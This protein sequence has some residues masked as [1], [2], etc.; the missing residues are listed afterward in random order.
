MLWFRRFGALLM[1]SLGVSLLILPFPAR[2]NGEKTRELLR[3]EVREGPYDRDSAARR[4]GVDFIELSYEKMEGRP[5][6]REAV[7]SLMDRSGS[8]C[9]SAEEWKDLLAEFSRTDPQGLV[10][11]FRDGIYRIVEFEETGDEHGRDFICCD[12]EYL[13]VYNNLEWGPI[14]LLDRDVLDSSQ[15]LA[16]ALERISLSSLPAGTTF[17]MSRKS[18]ERILR[19]SS[20]DALLPRFLRFEGK[21]ISWDFQEETELSVVEVSWL[22]KAAASGGVLLIVIG[23]LIGVGSYKSAWNRKGDPISSLRQALFLELVVLA[24]TVFFLTLFLDLLWIALLGRDSLLGLD[25][26][27]PSS[28]VITGLHFVSIPALFV[29]IPLLSLF[30]AGLTSQRVLIDKEGIRSFGMLSES[31]IG[32]DRLEEVEIRGQRNP[33]AFTVFDFR[34]LQ[35]VIDLK[36]GG[37][38]VTI[39]EPSSRKSKR[40]ILEKL[41]RFAPKK[42]LPLVER[43]ESW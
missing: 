38:T 25:P 41:V 3:L 37:K 28:Q 40:K 23:L 31:F 27:W 21:L 36:G 12:V 34:S 14:P 19:N 22:P 10:Y 15:E 17:E 42:K 30:T 43:L 24:G 13:G 11:S 39:N 35:R 20:G 16:S 33:L 5:E 26:E 29:G 1:V 7:L 6:V 2:F 18:W 4:F 8:R 32:W 9:S